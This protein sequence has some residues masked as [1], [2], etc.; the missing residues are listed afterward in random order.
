MV[1]CLAILTYRMLQYV[2]APDSLSEDVLG[3]STT[4]AVPPT[5]IRSGSGGMIHGLDDVDLN[6][7]SMEVI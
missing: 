3:L 2:K 7:N 5:P 1:L 4:T 6:S